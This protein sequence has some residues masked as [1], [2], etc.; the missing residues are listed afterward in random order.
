LN[1]DKPIQ[2]INTANSET[3]NPVLLSHEDQYKQHLE[4]AHEAITKRFNSL[5]ELAGVVEQNPPALS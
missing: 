2:H 5:R 3:E 4:A 1:Q